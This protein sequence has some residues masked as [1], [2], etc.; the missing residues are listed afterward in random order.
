MC[1]V[2][3][4]GCSGRLC[5]QILYE[6]LKSGHPAIGEYFEVSL[7]V[8]KPFNYYF[9]Y[10]NTLLLAFTAVVLIFPGAGRL[11]VNLHIPASIRGGSP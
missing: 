4:T 11:L 1:T 8:F 2:G 5:L 3:L 6:Y 7:S 10:F 9:M